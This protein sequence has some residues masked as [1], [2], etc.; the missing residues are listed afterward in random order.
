[1]FPLLF[2]L[3]LLSPDTL[4][5]IGIA[6]VKIEDEDLMKKRKG[7]KKVPICTGTLFLNN[8]LKYIEPPYEGPFTVAFIAFPVP[9]ELKGTIFTS[10]VAPGATDKAIRVAVVVLM[11]APFEIM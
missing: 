4:E 6:K 5:L 2:S 8:R 11:M 7:K 3:T 9:L 1:M 10:R